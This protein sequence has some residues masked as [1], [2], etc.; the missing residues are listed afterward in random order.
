MPW[1]INRR[2]WIWLHA[3]KLRFKLTYISGVRMSIES[4]KGANVGLT[5]PISTTKNLCVPIWIHVSYHQVVR[6]GGAEFI[7]YSRNYLS[8]ATLC[9]GFVDVNNTFLFD[10]DF[11]HNSWVVFFIRRMLIYAIY[12]IYFHVWYS[13]T[14]II[15]LTEN[16]IFTNTKLFGTF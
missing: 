11:V 16:I 6:Q 8:P 2:L 4:T 5:L 14:P 15:L 12:A 13:F 3:F 9:C 1:K 7:L 10:S